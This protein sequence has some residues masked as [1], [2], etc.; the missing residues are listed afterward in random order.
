MMAAWQLQLLAHRRV[1]RSLLS[2]CLWAL[3]PGG[4]MLGGCVTSS[5]VIAAVPQAIPNVVAD[6]T[7]Y[8]GA[9]PGRLADVAA[10]KAA[11]ANPTTP[12]LTAAWAAVKAWYVPAFATDTSLSATELEVRQAQAAELNQLLSDDAARPFAQ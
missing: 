2:P 8:A 11:A 7:H 5:A 3:V 1:T 10:L 9:N 6:A 12:G 4:L